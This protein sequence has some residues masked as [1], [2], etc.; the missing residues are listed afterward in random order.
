MGKQSTLG[1]DYLATVWPV[2]ACVSSGLKKSSCHAA[3]RAFVPVQGSAVSRDSTLHRY[4]GAYNTDILQKFFAAFENWELKLVL[5]DLKKAGFPTDKSIHLLAG[6]SLSDAPSTLLYRLVVNWTVFSDARIQELIG[7]CPPTRP[8]LDWPAGNPPPG[9]LGLLMH[10]SPEV[11]EWARQQCPDNSTTLM[12]A[13]QF[14]DSYVNAL[15][16]MAGAVP[17]SSSTTGGL[18]FSSDPTV[19]WSAIHTMLRMVPV[20]RL[21][22]LRVQAVSLRLF[23]TLHLRDSGPG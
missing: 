3:Q 18:L 12:T 23:V 19:I 2:A 21:R 20:D 14:T 17:G 11:R 4:F 22:T 8:P 9:M 16:T 5:D 15:T 6:K 1:R 7:T 10:K 13:P